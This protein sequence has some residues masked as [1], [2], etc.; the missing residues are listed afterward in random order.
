MRV[1]LKKVKAD[2]FSS[3]VWLVLGVVV[4]YYSKTLGLG[5]ISSPGPGFL[6]FGPA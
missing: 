6:P 5:R 1:N 4:V 2:K 3:A